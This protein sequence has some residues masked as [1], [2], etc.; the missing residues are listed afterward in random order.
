MCEKGNRKFRFYL[1]C[2]RGVAIQFSSLAVL[3]YFNIYFVGRGTQELDYCLVKCAAFLLPLL[4]SC[5][6]S[7]YWVNTR[8][9]EDNWLRRSLFASLVLQRSGL[10]FICS[11]A[12]FSKN[13]LSRFR[14]K[15]SFHS[16]KQHLCHRKTVK[17][18]GG[19][20]EGW[21][22]RRFMCGTGVGWGKEASF[23]WWVLMV[24]IWITRAILISRFKVKWI[25]FVWQKRLQL[26]WVKSR[27]VREWIPVLYSN[28]APPGPLTF[29]KP[30]LLMYFHAQSV[31]FRQ[32][33]PGV[34]F[35]KD[36]PTTTV[37][38]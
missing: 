11:T 10:P 18:E 37:R 12:H 7:G 32:C 15:N 34:T 31:L 8:D 3:N 16:C 4:K 33:S 26:H 24:S 20:E 19:K 14:I 30:R 38:S 36:C 23:H 13:R 28:V 1:W 27:Q 22:N 6:C 2:A 17:C 5:S 29:I 9:K 35:F 21:S 25:P